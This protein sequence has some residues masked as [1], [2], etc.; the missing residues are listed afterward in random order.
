LGFGE[1]WLFFVLGYALGY[2]VSDEV[3]LVGAEALG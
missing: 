3:V 2:G 1:F